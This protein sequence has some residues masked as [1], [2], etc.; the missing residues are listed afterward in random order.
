VEP[1]ATPFKTKN[2]FTYDVVITLALIEAQLFAIDASVRE[3]HIDEIK[4][5]EN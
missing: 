4:Y 2:D 1:I 3:Y 5:L